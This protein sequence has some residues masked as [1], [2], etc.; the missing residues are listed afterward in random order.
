MDSRTAGCSIFVVIRWRPFLI[1]AIAPPI[2]AR[3]SDS[4]PQDVKTRFFSF[5]FRI[6]A[7]VFFASA[8]CLSA[9]TPLWCMLEGLPYSSRYIL[10]ISST[11]SGKHRVVAELS[12][13][14]SLMFPLLLL[15]AGPLRFFA[16]PLFAVPCMITHHFADYKPFLACQQV[17]KR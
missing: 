6:C 4:E 13:Y 16:G 5:T 11:T 8:I 3:L 10:F 2:M 9:S 7:R 12:R 1:L 15:L 14:A 17:S